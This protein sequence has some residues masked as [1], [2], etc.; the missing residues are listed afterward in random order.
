MMHLFTK[1]VLSV[2]IVGATI[3]M[4]HAQAVLEE[5]TVTATKRTDTAGCADFRSRCFF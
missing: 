1:T 3:S 5:V 2:A 4:A